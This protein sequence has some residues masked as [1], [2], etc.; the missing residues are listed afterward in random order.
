MRMPCVRALGAVTLLVVLPHL[1]IGQLRSPTVPVA[2]RRGLSVASVR[3]GVDSMRYLIAEERPDAAAAVGKRLLRQAPADPRLRAW[4]LA[5]L[6][7]ARRFDELWAFVRQCRGRPSDAW[8]AVECAYELATRSRGWRVGLDSADV[9][10]RAAVAQRPGD[11]EIALLAT[12]LF[13]RRVEFSTHR[14]EPVLVFLDSAVGRTKGDYDL[15]AWRAAVRYDAAGVTPVDTVVQRAALR[16]L[17][18]LRRDQPTRVPAYHL[19]VERLLRRSP[20]EALPLITHALT[21]QPASVEL[22]RDYWALLTR[23]PEAADAARRAAVINDVAAWV[24]EMDSATNVLFA[25]S[26]QLRDVKS[27]TL[28]QLLEE[29]LLAR[30][31]VSREADELRWRRAR[32]W[33]DSLRALSDSTSAH[34]GADSVRLR[35][36]RIR[37]FDALVFRHPFSSSLTRASAAADLLDF[38]RADSSYPAPKLLAAARLVRAAPLLQTYATHGVTAVALAERRVA[39]QEAERWT[40][41]GS[42]TVWRELDDM[43]SLYPSMGE[44]VAALERWQTVFSVARAVVQIAARQYAAAEATLDGALKLSPG[45]AD[46]QYQVGR[47]R[48]IQHRR[49]D[50]ELAFVRALGGRD[51]LGINESRRDLER[52]Y[53]ERQGSLAGWDAYL[54]DVQRREAD[55]RRM[56]ILASA[57]AD[58]P[59]PPP[60]ALKALDGRV[61]TSESLK[62]KIAIVNFWGTW[63]GPCV[64]EM[65]ALQK[66]YDKYQSDTAVAIVTIAKDALADVQAWMAAKRYTIPTLLDAGYSA[67]ALIPVW[68]TTWVLDRDGRLRYRLRSTPEQLVEEWSWVIEAMRGPGGMK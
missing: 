4:Y 14:Y 48:L 6:D 41:E 40:I 10:L 11:P 7:Q 56:K 1:L 26:K 59:S 67:R 57:L 22:R 53:I 18:E 33:T 45:D 62:G 5:S 34:P 58:A 30:A 13:V 28:A 27:D 15:R 54:I 66:L 32:M 17:A 24:T 19:A 9:Y 16:E 64:G 29:R 35:A 52:L 50:A 60:F 55:R 44:R 25:A 23:Q 63:C 38:V 61:V 65:P 8:R 21:L 39:L 42:K 12:W 49:D 2:P 3:A 31:P 68:P 43:S 47:L 20:G 36:V 51:V 37:A 46:V